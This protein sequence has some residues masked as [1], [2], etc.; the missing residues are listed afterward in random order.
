MR[1]E[2]SPMYMDVNLLCVASSGDRFAFSIKKD[3]RRIC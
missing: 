1:L 3:D 2:E